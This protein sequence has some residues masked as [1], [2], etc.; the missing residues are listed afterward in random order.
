MY[1]AYQ[2]FV[3]AIYIGFM[4]V[5]ILRKKECRLDKIMGNIALVMALSGFFIPT[6]FLIQFSQFY[7]PQR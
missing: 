4:A 3:W 2:N 1:F 6:D 5:R 7:F